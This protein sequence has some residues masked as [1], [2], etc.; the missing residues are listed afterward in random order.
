MR[1]WG[2][3]SIDEASRNAGREW[4]VDGLVGIEIEIEIGIGIGIRIGIDSRL[5]THDSR[6]TTHGR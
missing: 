2:F 4:S 1:A 6:F 5:T 3:Y